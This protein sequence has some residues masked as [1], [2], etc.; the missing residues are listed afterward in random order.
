MIRAF[1]GRKLL[2]RFLS[3]LGASFLEIEGGQ[4]WHM[5]DERLR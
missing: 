5:A 2:A 4:E 1:V 3:Q